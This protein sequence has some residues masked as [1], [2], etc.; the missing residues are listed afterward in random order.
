MNHTFQQA[1]S[2][3]VPSR[4]DRLKRAGMGTIALERKEADDRNEYFMS[5]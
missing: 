3:C 2:G 1:N 4:S 5:A